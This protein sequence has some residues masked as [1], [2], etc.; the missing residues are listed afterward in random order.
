MPSKAKRPCSQPGCPELTTDRYC[1]KHKAQADQAMPSRSYSNLYGRKW[2]KY[3]AQYLVHNPLC[4]CDECKQ[5]DIPLPADV[6]DHIVPHKGDYALFWD[7]NNHQ[8]MAKRCHD[9]KTAKEDGGF[10]NN[11]RH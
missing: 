10:G 1:T 6:V 2:R 7:P 5:R 8:P 9:A 4:V 11:I 3:R